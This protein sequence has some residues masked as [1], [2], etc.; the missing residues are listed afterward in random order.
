MQALRDMW[1]RFTPTRRTAVLLFLGIV[2]A[3]FVLVSRCI[4]GQGYTGEEITSGERMLA[5]VNAWLKGPS[6]SPDAV[7]APRARSSAF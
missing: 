1:R 7:V 5:V 2:G 6:N 4:A 3:L